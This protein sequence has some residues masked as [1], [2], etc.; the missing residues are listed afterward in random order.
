VVFKIETR[1]F[2]LNLT[3]IQYAIF[4]SA[5]LSQE[6][7][8]RHLSAAGENSDRRPERVIL[9]LYARCQK[10]TLKVSY[11]GSNW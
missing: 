7:V 2:V 11:R 5:G 3:A 10:N 9:I 4:V 6:I 1:T 8:L